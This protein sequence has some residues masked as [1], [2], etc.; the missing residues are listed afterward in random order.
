MTRRRSVTA[1]AALAAAL[2]AACDLQEK[3]GPRAAYPYCAAFVKGD[4]LVAFPFDA[5]KATVTLPFVPARLSYSRDGKSLYAAR[6]YP[7]RR[8]GISRIDLRSGKV[9]AV[10]G[11]ADLFAHSFAVSPDGGKIVISGRYRKGDGEQCGIFELSGATGAVRRVPVPDNLD[12][13][14][15]YTWHD[16][17]LS[18]DG[19]RAVAFRQVGVEPEIELIDLILGTVTSLG[20]GSRAAWS[21]DGKWIAVLDYST[22]YAIT[23]MDPGDPSKRRGFGGTGDQELSWSPDSR[24]LLLW[25]PCLLSL[26]YFG[27]LEAL[28]VENGKRETIRSSRCAVNLMTSGWVSNEVIR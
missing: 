17:S 18:P 15:Q 7:D 9:T 26:G 23:V 11:S 16:L 22:N 6:Q 2:L 13:D 24:Y 10:P 1:A 5:E 14:Y 12:C 21:P 25:K 19:G 8:A 4:T 3:G 27:T 20:R 28:D